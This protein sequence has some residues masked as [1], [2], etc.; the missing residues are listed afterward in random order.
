M[1]FGKELAH[2]ESYIK[3]YGDYKIVGSY[4]VYEAYIEKMHDK[5]GKLMTNKDG[6]PRYRY[7]DD[8]DLSTLKEDKLVKEIRPNF[9]KDVYQVNSD[10]VEK[11]E[12]E[13]GKRIYF[14]VDPSKVKTLAKD[15]R[16]IIKNGTYRVLQEV[17]YVLVDD[18]DIENPKVIAV[19]KFKTEDHESEA[20][21]IVRNKLK[22]ITGED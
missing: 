1:L 3:E 8:R 9:Y 16:A 6:S 12:K 4:T 21:E 2:D 11:V 7:I 5:E 15:T 10:Y 19:R 20:K 18:Y 14:V 17:G 13:D 22:R